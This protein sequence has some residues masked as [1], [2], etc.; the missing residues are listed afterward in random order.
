MIF[1]WG[2]ALKIGWRCLSSGT[3]EKSVPLWEVMLWI[4]GINM[5]KLAPS[6]TEAA[7]T[8]KNIATDW[9]GYFFRYLNDTAANFIIYLF[10]QFLKLLHI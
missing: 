2:I 7:K 10:S 5:P 1:V 4:S 6:K 8:R 3:P 9:T